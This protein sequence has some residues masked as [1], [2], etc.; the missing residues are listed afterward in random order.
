MCNLVHY[1]ISFPGL[2]YRCQGFLGGPDTDDLVSWLTYQPKSQVSDS[3]ER[4]KISQNTPLSFAL[5]IYCILSE[6]H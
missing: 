5:Q 1:W 6:K 3:P 2:T 4:L